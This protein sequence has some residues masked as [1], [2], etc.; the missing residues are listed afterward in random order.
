MVGGEDKN[1]E[2]RALS[3][4]R[5]F[6]SLTTI[7]EAHSNISTVFDPKT[8]WQ[9]AIDFS[10][11]N[12]PVLSRRQA[13]HIQSLK[14]CKKSPGLRPTPPNLSHSGTSRAELTTPPHK[15][16]TFPGRKPCALAAGC[17]PTNK[18]PDGAGSVIKQPEIKSP[19]K[20]EGSSTYNSRARPCIVP[21]REKSNC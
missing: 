15:D 18:P 20:K 13:R 8:K 1:L 9:E 12:V 21:R 4:R 19:N 6:L 3:S 7:I 16:G 5:S 2:V 14:L 11:L 10:S 17:M